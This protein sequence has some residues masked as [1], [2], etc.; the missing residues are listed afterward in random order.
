MPMLEIRSADNPRIK[1]LRALLH[2]GRARSRESML[3]LEGEHLVR[4]WL[5]HERPL[6]ELVFDLG[7]IEAPAMER[8][9]ARTPGRSAIGISTALMRGLSTLQ[10]PPDVVALAPLPPAIAWAGGVDALALDAVQDPGNVGTMLR[11]AAAAGIGWAI[12]GAGSASP[13]SPKAL[14]A[15]MGAQAAMK[16]IEA[17]DLAAWL[18]VCDV[19]CLGTAGE[20]KQSLF[21]MDLRGPLIWVMGNEGAGLSAAV[22]ASLTEQLS[23]PQAPAVES[24]NVAGAAAVCLF[25][26]RR[27]RLRAD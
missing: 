14:R 3:V 18:K 21:A 20:A 19:R 6:T 26:M 13:W 27:Q 9:I 10:T 23:I 16:I 22:R 2:D 5:D 7:Q 15:G 17:D 4:A 25:E 12:L 1:R 8:L 24:L 11:T